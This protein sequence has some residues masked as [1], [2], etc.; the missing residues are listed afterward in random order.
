MHK[1][2]LGFGIPVIILGICILIFSQIRAEKNPAPVKGRPATCLKTQKNCTAQ[3]AP[4]SN[5]IF[6][7]NLSRQFISVVYTR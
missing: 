1:K 5:E 2:L 3:P 7:E 4:T 6:L